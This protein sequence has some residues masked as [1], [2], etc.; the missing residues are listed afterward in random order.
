LI[1]D[2]VSSEFQ[3]VIMG[4]PYEYTYLDHKDIIRTMTTKHVHSAPVYNT[5]TLENTPPLSLRDKLLLAYSI[6][7]YCVKIQPLF[8]KYS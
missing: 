5:P 7:V 8:I 2:T 4:F 1:A 6:T 3:K